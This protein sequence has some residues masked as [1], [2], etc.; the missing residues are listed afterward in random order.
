MGGTSTDVALVVDGEAQTTTGSIV[1]GIAIRHA[2]VDVH[3]VS[4]GGGSIAWADDGGALRVGPQSAG[5]RPGPASYGLGGIEATVT[6]ADLYLGYLADAARLGGEIELRHTFAD[7]ALAALGDALGLTPLE[8]A[9]GVTT[10]AEAEMVRALRVISI[11]R[12]FDPRDFTLVAFGGAGGMHSCRLAEELEIST[13]LVPR[14]GGVLSALGLAISDLRRDYVAALIGDLADLDATEIEAAFAQ[15]E[16]RSL[17]EQPGA[18]LR[19]FADL[20]CRGQSFELTVPAD[21]LDGL[22]ARFAAAHRRRYGFEM[23]DARVQIVSVRVT[24]TVAVPKPPLARLE[25]AGDAGCS[26]R[27]AH[28]DGAWLDVDV[29]RPG[30]LVVGSMID[31][32][33]IVEF[34]EATCVVRP[35][36]S[37]RVDR[38]G[39]LVLE[40][41]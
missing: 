21:D 28:F 9:V 41:A 39:A 33:A 24:A 32:P 4:A 23:R 11:E 31:G 38:T 14:T 8:A 22:D 10:V 27:S 29:F 35:D 12:G 1:A 2:M 13:V 26:A 37:A 7:D 18:V 15:L 25:L 19:R 16:G 30:D 36:W 3:T 40:R 17:V 6:D 5:A 34:P 20:R